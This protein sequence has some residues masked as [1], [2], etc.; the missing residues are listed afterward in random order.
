L[1]REGARPD[2]LLV[3]G[4]NLTVDRTM[5]LPALVPGEVLRA[6]R[7]EVTP[8]GKGVNV[9]RAARALGAPATLVAFVPGRTG[10]AVAELLA[11][12]GTRLEAVE[13]AGEVR[14]TAIVMEADGRVTVI[15][16]PGPEL[17][18][19]GWEALEEAVERLLPAHAALVC[20]GSVPPGAPP[21]AY[22]RLAARASAS[23]TFGVTTLVPAAT[24]A[25][26]TGPATSTTAGRPWAAARAARRA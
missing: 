4:P 2:G 24:A 23:P 19:G 10:R 20:S 26:R 3:V 7:V 16:E 12:E 15:N 22:A 18:P 25:A 14:S 13:A 6:R 17:A 8:G 9:V 5:A 1:S 11:G 21:D